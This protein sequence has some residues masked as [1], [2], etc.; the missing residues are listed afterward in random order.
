[1]ICSCGLQVEFTSATA[2]GP[3]LSDF[4]YLFL[5]NCKHCHSTRAALLW[6]AADDDE[7]P[8]AAE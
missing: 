8:I 3:M 5:V 1:M 2:V 4:A 7:Q 6:E